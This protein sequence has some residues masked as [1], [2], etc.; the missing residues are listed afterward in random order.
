MLGGMN[1]LLILVAGLLLMAQAGAQGI[2]HIQTEGK[3]AAADPL[4]CVALKAVKKSSTPADIIQGARECIRKSNYDQA[5]K[6]VMVAGTRAFY[7]TRRVADRSAHG[8]FPAMMTSQ[9][10]NTL[11]EEERTAFVAQWEAAHGQDAP[12]KQEVCAFLASS[13][14]PTYRP[15]YMI[16]HGLAALLRPDQEPLVADFNPYESWR[17][18][19]ES[20]GCQRN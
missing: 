15:D 11:S 7:D 12:L 2:R 9:I 17:Q 14:P 1:R 4:W 5:I 13:K 3:L 18:A 19:L 6:L 20:A 16:N 8:A 10:S